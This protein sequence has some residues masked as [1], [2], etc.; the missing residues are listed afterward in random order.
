[1]DEVVT[2]WFPKLQQARYLKIFPRD[3]T[4]RWSGGADMR[5]GILGGVREE[6]ASIEYLEVGDVEQSAR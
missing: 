5:V 2:N 3:Y 4:A 6:G 1:M